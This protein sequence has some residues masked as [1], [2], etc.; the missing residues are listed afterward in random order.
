MGGYAAGFTAEDGETRRVHLRCCGC[1]AEAADLILATDCTEYTDYFTA[2]AQRR[3][4][5]IDL[6]YQSLK[7]LCS[8]R[9]FIN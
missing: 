3:S 2:E 6:I 8:V 5:Y 1:A 9:D 4:C 7:H